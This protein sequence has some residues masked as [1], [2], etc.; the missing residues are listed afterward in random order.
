[1]LINASNGDGCLV[2]CPCLCL[3]QLDIWFAVMHLPPPSPPIRAV[4]ASSQA[5]RAAEASASWRGRMR[6][7]RRS[8]KCRRMGAGRGVCAPAAGGCVWGD[9]LPKATRRWTVAEG[10]FVEP[11]TYLRSNSTNS[12]TLKPASLMSFLRVPLSSSRC[13]GTESVTIRPDFTIMT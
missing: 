3:W 4:R 10:V 8:W 6:R 1:M 9:A 13:F 7:R 5:S 11:P 12:P 2:G